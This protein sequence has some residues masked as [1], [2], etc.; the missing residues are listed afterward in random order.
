MLLE[1]LPAGGGQ[2]VI[3]RAPIVLRDLPF[4][5]QLAVLFEP[6]QRGEERAGVDA[7][8]VVAED[9]KPL[10]LTMTAAE[11]S[12]VGTAHTGVFVGD[13][14]RQTGPPFDSVPFV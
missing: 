8:V 1:L 9:G 2:T 12:R 11:T 10:W 7:E 4:G 5:L 14:F 3:L 6:V 13:I